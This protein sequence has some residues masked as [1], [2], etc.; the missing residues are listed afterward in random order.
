MGVRIYRKAGSQNFLPAVLSVRCFVDFLLCEDEFFVF[1]F[2][3][4]SLYVHISLVVSVCLRYKLIIIIFIVLCQK[5]R[6]SFPLRDLAARELYVKALNP[7]PSTLN[8]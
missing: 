4:L 5:P 8:P 3:S 2:P 1:V 7:K 6:R